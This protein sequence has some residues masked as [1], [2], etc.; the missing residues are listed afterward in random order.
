MSLSRDIMLSMCPTACIQCVAHYVALSTRLHFRDFILAQLRLL[1][2]TR[3]SPELT[4]RGSDLPEAATV[5][6]TVIC[7]KV[8]LAG[9]SY[10][11]C[12]TDLSRISE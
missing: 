7:A 1:N 4:N 8:S 3:L 2:Y 6:V 11:F 12:A 9:Y 10:D 5:K